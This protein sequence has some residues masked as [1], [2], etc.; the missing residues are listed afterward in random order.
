VANV[1]Q[2]LI[3]LLIWSGR[4]TPSE[5]ARK[6]TNVLLLIMVV[7]IGYVS[8]QLTLLQ[9]NL[10]GVERKADVTEVRSDFLEKWTESGFTQLDQQLLALEQRVINLERRLINQEQR[11]DELFTPM[12]PSP[13]K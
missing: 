5:K 13:A 6:L 2:C 1:L 7:G 9:S 3:S 12:Q 11:H 4:E 8:Y 10:H